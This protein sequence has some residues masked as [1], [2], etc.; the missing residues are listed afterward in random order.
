MTVFT[1]FFC[2]NN[3]YFTKEKGCFNLNTLAGEIIGD[4]HITVYETPEGYDF[5][6]LQADNDNLL[7]ILD[8]IEDTLIKY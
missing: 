4:I 6:Q 7:P 2:Y 8:I 5:F 1:Y 3:F